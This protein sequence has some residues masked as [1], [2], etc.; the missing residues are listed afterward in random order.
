MRRGVWTALVLL[1][2]LNLWALVCL[3]PL[4]LEWLV[5]DSRQLVLAAYALPL[6]FLGLGWSLRWSGLL[7]F[8]FPVSF[9]PVYLALPEADQAVHESFWGWVSLALS[10]GMF[11][12]VAS[13]WLRRSPPRRLPGTGAASA[14][15][16]AALASAG[17][18]SEAS[19]GHGVVALM[20]GSAPGPTV[21]ARD[22]SAIEAE[23]TSRPPLRRHLW[24]PYQ[25]YFRPR[26]VL[27]LLLLWVPI[28]GLNFT[29]GVSARYASGFGAQSG[30][31]QVMANI[32]FMFAWVAVAYLYFFSPGLNLE[33]EQR[34]LDLRFRRAEKRALRGPTW[35]WL[36]AAPALA[37]GL[38]VVLFAWRI[39]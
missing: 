8:L 35:V 18:G 10:L 25:H 21:S 22:G 33:L 23:P 3:M 6:I 14:L 34:E 16:S 27:L 1:L 24:W 30:H 15:N 19:G 37:F 28:Y 17:A 31:A 36:F 13:L 32:I 38:M 29:E 12:G 9:A 26:W 5:E 4:Q 7:L 11:L 39:W 20:K 2:G